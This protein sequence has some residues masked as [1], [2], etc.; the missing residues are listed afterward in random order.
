MR[1]LRAEQPRDHARVH[2]IVTAA[3]GRDNEARLVDA[4]RER[5]RP[6]VSWVAEEA[7][8]VVGHVLVSPVV[9]ASAP[10]TRDLAGLAPVAVDPSRHGVG[11]GGALVRAA[12]E[13]AGEQGWRA[14]FLVGSP[15]YYARFGFV[16]AAPRGFTYGD[17]AVD[18]ALQAIELEPGALAGRSGLVQFHPAFVET[19]C[20]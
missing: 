1:T 2:E 11:I 3:F 7:D 12:L 8:A 17:P 6:T 13:A 9:L 16:P 18:P 15:A 14:V 5:A 10:G 4:L 19:G 20:G